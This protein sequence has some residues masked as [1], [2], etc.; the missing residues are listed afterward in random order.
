M[1]ETP[2]ETPPTNSAEARSGT[3]ELKDQNSTVLSTET[4]A[5]AKPEA[6]PAEKPA[7]GATLL[8]EGDKPKEAATGAPEAYKDFTAPEGF[9]IDKEAIASALPIFKE[10]NL[11]QEG[12]QKLVDLYATMSRQAAEAPMQ[13][14]KETQDK[15]VA[16][17]KA[18]PEIGGKLD[19]VKATVAR[20]V[21]GLGDPKLAADF[22]AAMDY[23]GAGNN[24]AFIRTF[25]KL[26]QQLS[27]GRPVSG[28]GPSP[29]GQA[30]PGTKP[31]SIANALY[32]NNP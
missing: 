7:E 28:N 16:E 25:Y 3:G 8:T 11:P 4:P 27:E 23:T 1:R 6:A 30:A 21:D 10:L 24:P 17:V 22:R 29:L 18:D 20:A 19:Q 9:E 32:P 12:A 31:R 14:W 15:W 13:L 26:A 5:S 2:L